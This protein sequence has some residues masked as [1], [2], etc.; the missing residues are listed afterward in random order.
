MKSEKIVDALGFRFTAGQINT[1][2]PKGTTPEER[3]AYMAKE[4]ASL[5]ERYPHCTT[6]LIFHESCGGP[7]PT[8]LIGYPLPDEDPG[9]K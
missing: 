5:R 9:A 2:V 4:I 1:P 6:V 7:L 8:E 3:E